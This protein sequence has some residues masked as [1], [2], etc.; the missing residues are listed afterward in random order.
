[1]KIN[2]L[3]IIQEVAHCDS[4]VKKTRRPAEDV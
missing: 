1:M 2:F 3:D 4:V